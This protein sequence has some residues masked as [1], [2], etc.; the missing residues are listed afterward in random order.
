[1]VAF[2]FE[3][4]E[5]MRK[6]RENA[7]NHSV[8]M[9]QGLMSFQP[10]KQGLG[11]IQPSSRKHMMCK[12]PKVFLKSKYKGSI[13]AG[14]GERKMWYSLEKQKYSLRSLFPSPPTKMSLSEL[15][16]ELRDPTVFL[17]KRGHSSLSKQPF[18]SYRKIL[19]GKTSLFAKRCFLFIWNV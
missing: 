16:M 18:Q 6:M 12:I 13:G 3:A 5:K 14:T 8:W 2:E 17:H 10:E 4:W 19:E 9:N 7:I 15:C 1:M 11:L